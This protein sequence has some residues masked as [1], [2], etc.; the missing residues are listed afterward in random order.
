MSGAAGRVFVALLKALFWGALAAE[1]AWVTLAS[2]AAE[3]V[4]SAFD[5]GVGP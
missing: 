4:A 1:V 2:A 5:N 3:T